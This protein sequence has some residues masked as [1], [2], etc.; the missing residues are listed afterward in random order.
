M[1]K[2]AYKYCKEKQDS[3]IKDYKLKELGI[4]SVQDIPSNS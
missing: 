4:N 1:N 3:L 2:S